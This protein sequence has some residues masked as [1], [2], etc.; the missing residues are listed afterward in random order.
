MPMVAV[1]IKLDGEFKDGLQPTF[2]L[3]VRFEVRN[4]KLV[5]ALVDWSHLTLV[6]EQFDERH[7]DV[8]LREKTL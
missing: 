6:G 3:P 7:W 2:L 4:N 1:D 5:C 8:S